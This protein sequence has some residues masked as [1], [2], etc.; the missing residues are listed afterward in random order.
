MRLLILLEGP[1]TLHE[2]DCALKNMNNNK[3]PGPDGFTSEFYQVFW[4]D[5]SMYFLR[6]LNFGYNSG[7]LL[8][9]SQRRSVITLIPKGNKPRKCLTNWRPISLLNVSYKLASA[10]IANRLKIVLPS[11]TNPVQTGFMKNLYIGEN[12]RILYDVM[13]YVESI[14]IPGLLF[15]IDFA[16][17]FDTISHSYILDVLNFF[18]FGNSF[19]KWFKLFYN[20]VSSCVLVNGWRSNFFSIG[21]GVRQGDPLSPYLFIIGVEILGYFIRCNNSIKGICV[22]QIEVKLSQ[23]AD[24]TLFFLDGSDNSLLYCTNALRF[25][26]DISRLK[27]NNDK[28]KL[29][30]IG[31][32][33]CCNKGLKSGENFIRDP[34]ISFDYLGIT[35]SV[36]LPNIVTCRLYN[37]A[38]DSI[39]RLIEVWSKRFLTVLGRVVIVKSLMISKLTFI[40]TLISNPDCNMIKTLKGMLFKFVWQSSTDRVSRIQMV[41]IFEKGGVKMI[42]F[43]S[44]FD[45]LKVSWI[46]RL[47]NSSGQWVDIFLL[48]ITTSFEL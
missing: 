3:S 4:S 42:D 33:K 2:I 36:D 48:F 19:C 18:H 44:H 14:N 32:E 24:D 46:K 35:F 47:N 38:F 30:W 23:Y 22:N 9:V 34:G 8:S 37:K 43:E 41:Q 6:S 17:A 27:L 40:A 29:I 10:C 39:K 45:A 13:H 11:I 26:G 16:K 7:G 12:I 28:S 20:N 1:L 15:L 21:R 25:F 31:S 5:I